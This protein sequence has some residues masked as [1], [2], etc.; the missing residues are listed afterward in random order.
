MT[1][2]QWTL[3]DLIK[4]AEQI[5]APAGRLKLEELEEMSRDEVQETLMNLATEA[6]ELREKM[7]GETNMRELERIVMLRVIDNHWMEH[8]DDMDMLREGIGLLSYGQ[9]NPL[10]EYKIKGHDMFQSMIDAIQTDIAT[11]MY[12][13]NIITPEQQRAMEEQ[14]KQRL[15]QAK[16]SHS[17][18]EGD[19]EPAKKQPVVK[20]EK[21]GRN[22]PCPCGSGKKYKNCCGRDK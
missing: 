1:L 6:Y 10:V 20:G 13:V 3:G 16:S 5:Y 8:L 2:E 18:A 19:Q 4:D 14:A 12:R 9:R 17:S 22:D 21:I 11:M 15:A 7:F